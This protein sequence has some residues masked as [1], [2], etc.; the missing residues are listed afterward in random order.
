MATVSPVSPM[1]AWESFF[2]EMC[3]FLLS[4]ERQSSTGNANESFSH[5]VLEKFSV[6]CSN[7]SSLLIHMQATLEDG[8]VSDGESS[9]ISAYVS[10][11]VEVLQ[12]LQT[13]AREWDLYLDEI[14]Q[15]SHSAMYL[16]PTVLVAHRR[17]GR[18][19]FDI[20][21][22]Q[23]E[24]LSSMSFSWTQ[25]ASMLGVSRMTIYRRRMEYGI[26]SPRNSLS[27]DELKVVLQQVNAEQPALG[28]TMLWGRLKSMGFHVTRSRLRFAIREVDPLQRA[29]RWSAQ[30]ARRQPYSVPGPNSLWHIGELDQRCQHSE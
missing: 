22:D 4:A 12:N 1:R 10:M 28:E 25:V 26:A 14:Y 9:V 8:S 24:Y 2:D 20:S 30:L 11:L 27:D 18:P 21:H 7:I 19:R 6:Y 23:L 15:V 29:L 13:T 16:A 3:S 5:Y 17:R